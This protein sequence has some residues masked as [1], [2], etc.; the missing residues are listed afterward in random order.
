MKFWYQQKIVEKANGSNI[1]TINLVVQFALSV[2]FYPLNVVY[3]SS[4]TISLSKKSPNA[5]KN[6]TKNWQENWKFKPYPKVC[7]NFGQFGQKFSPWALKSCPNGNKS[8]NPVTL[9]SRWWLMNKSNIPLRWQFEIET[10]LKG[11][12]RDFAWNVPTY[13]LNYLP[14]Y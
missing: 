7:Q 2:E 8:C 12:F 9:P 4:V 3:S 10:S 13:I 5:L 1:Y 14:I 11:K 6:S